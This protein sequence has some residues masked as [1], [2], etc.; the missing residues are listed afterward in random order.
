MGRNRSVDVWIH[1]KSNHIVLIVLQVQNVKFL[2]TFHVGMWELL[3]LLER[4]TKMPAAG[5]QALAPSGQAQGPRY[6]FMPH[7]LVS[8][9]LFGAL[10][11][12]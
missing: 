8:C 5:S 1:D 10:C 12:T 6:A 11:D 2:L 7:L 9:P 4:S 3:Q